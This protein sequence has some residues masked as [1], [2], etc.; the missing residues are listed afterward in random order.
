MT[1]SSFYHLGWMFSG[2]FFIMLLID[3]M[4]EVPFKMFRNEEK[5]GSWVGAIVALAISVVGGFIFLYV[6]EKI[7]NYYWYEPFTGGNY[8]DDPRFRHLHVAEI[9]AFFMLAILIVKVFFNNVIQSANKWLNAV[10]RLVVVSASG[11]LIYWFYY[12]ETLG[13]KFVDRVPGIGSVDDTSLCWTIMSMAL[14]MA[15]DKFFN[16]YPLRR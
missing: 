4:D 1:A 12:S 15:Y 6:A 3:C 14:I 11:M 5:S 7:M 8:T 13:P 9:G 10:V 2:M 16:A